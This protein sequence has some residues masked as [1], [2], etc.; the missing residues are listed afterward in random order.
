[1]R[2]IQVQRRPPRRADSEP[3]RAEYH[4]RPSAGPGGSREGDHS[5]EPSALPERLRAGR[6]AAGLASALAEGVPIRTL[7]GAWLVRKV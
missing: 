6:E 3:P 4:D 7:A 2:Q 5:T 1:V